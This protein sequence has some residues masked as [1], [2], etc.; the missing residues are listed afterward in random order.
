[1]ADRRGEVSW[2]GPALVV[3]GLL[4]V[5]LDVVG[6]FVLWLVGDS[7]GWFIAAGWPR[8]PTWTLLLVVAVACIAAGFWRMRRT[9][10]G[11]ISNQ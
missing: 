5:M 6:W 8:G 10:D 11:P 1:M 9:P 3:V 2:L 4:L 7:T